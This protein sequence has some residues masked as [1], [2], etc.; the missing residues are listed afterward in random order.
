M[1]PCRSS[2]HAF[3][4]MLSQS[5]NLPGCTS[6]H[7]RVFL[8]FQGIFI[9]CVGW[10]SNAAGPFSPWCPHGSRH[11]TARAASFSIS[12]WRSCLRGYCIFA[13]QIRL[14]RRQGVCEGVG[15]QPAQQSSSQPTGLFGEWVTVVDSLFGILF[16]FIK[17]QRPLTTVYLWTNY[18]WEIIKL[19]SL[20][21][22]MKIEI[23]HGSLLTTFFL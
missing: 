12:S 16:G 9:P 6:I 21:S 19:V 18:L 15:Y 17:I 13:N 4:V 3:T 10:G 23:S 2:C 7:I 8:L 20:S 5:V 1:Y 11:T 14:H 22:V